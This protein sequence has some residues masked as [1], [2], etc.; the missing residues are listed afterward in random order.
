MVFCWGRKAR[1]LLVVLIACRGCRKANGRTASVETDAA[2]VEGAGDAEASTVTRD[3]TAKPLDTLEH[4]DMHELVLLLHRAAA[5]AHTM[6]HV[7]STSMSGREF[8][9]L[10]AFDARDIFNC[11]A[12]VRCMQ[13]PWCLDCVSL[14]PTTRTNSRRTEESYS[15]SSSESV[16]NG[17]ADDLKTESDAP[18]TAESDIRGSA[19]SVDSVARGA[20]VESEDAEDDPRQAIERVRE[21]ARLIHPN[22]LL[23]ARRHAEARRRPPSASNRFVVWTCGCCG[24]PCSGWGNRILGIVSA[25]MFAVLS[26]RAFLIHWPDNAC[27]PLSDYIMSEWID[28]RLPAGFRSLL[29]ATEQYFLV[30]WAPVHGFEMSERYQMLKSPAYVPDDTHKSPTDTGVPQLPQHRPPLARRQARRL[31]AG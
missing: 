3:T 10:S 22:L 6:S 12:G 29:S 7:R 4:V 19:Y 28:W 23:Y 31:A 26:D 1:L 2:H 30:N 27:A 8:A 20:A 13:P 25:L 15:H 16:D 9:R 17:A 24:D 11:T 21:N 5:P 14:V 18:Q